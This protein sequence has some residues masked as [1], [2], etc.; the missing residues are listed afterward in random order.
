[1]QIRIAQDINKVE[2]EGL[3]T[4]VEHSEAVDSLFVQEWDEALNM[5][6]RLVTWDGGDP[7]W[8]REKEKWVGEL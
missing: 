8:V 5:D 3:A 7:G 2:A 4:T 6:L 1:M